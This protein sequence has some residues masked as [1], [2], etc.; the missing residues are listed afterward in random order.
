MAN[1]GHQIAV[2]ARLRSE[3]AKAVLAVVEGDSLQKANEY[4]LGRWFGTGLHLV[5]RLRLP[6]CVVRGL[7]RSRHREMSNRC[8]LLMI[9]TS[10]SCS[11][12]IILHVTTY[13]SRPRRLRRASFNAQS[14]RLPRSKSDPSGP[15]TD[16]FPL[17]SRRI[18][19][20]YRI[21]R[22]SPVQATRLSLTPSRGAFIEKGDFQDLRLNGLQGAPRWRLS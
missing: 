16:Q 4:F 5:L 19:Q 7:T 22:F 20:F 18:R 6:A 17:V 15:Q 3:N 2:A 11:S 12:L 1:D 14:A 9:L 13:L 8:E 21:A 10:D